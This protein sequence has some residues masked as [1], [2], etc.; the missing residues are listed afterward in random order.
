MSESKNTKVEK[1]GT[2]NNEKVKKAET[3]K[4]VKTL[5]PSK[6][7]RLDRMENQ[8]QLIG[9]G[10]LV[11]INSTQWHNLSITPIGTHNPDKLIDGFIS[12]QDAVEELHLKDGEL[13]AQ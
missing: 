2:V 7:D 8:L 9:D 12:L 11:L 4:V 1:D 13:V 5:E 10:L 6:S 3:E